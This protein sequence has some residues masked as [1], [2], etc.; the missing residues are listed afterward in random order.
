MCVF[1]L[2]L[3]HFLYGFCEYRGWE[4]ARSQQLLTICELMCRTGVCV[5]WCV[6]VYFYE[7]CLCN[8]HCAHV[9]LCENLSTHR[10]RQAK[11]NTP[12]SQVRDGETG[13]DWKINH[14]YAYFM[15]TIPLK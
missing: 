9:M 15:S 13:M 1:A 6:R 11:A 2:L 8:V 5:L 3:F 14:F 12:T 4:Y 7:E 10:S